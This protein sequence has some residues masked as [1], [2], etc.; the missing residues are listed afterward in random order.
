MLTCYVEKVTT[1]EINGQMCK[2]TLK[3]SK[4]LPKQKG[5]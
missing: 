2:T 3:F 5:I 1:S 4:V